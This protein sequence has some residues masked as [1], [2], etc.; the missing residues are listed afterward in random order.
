MRARAKGLTALAALC[1]GLAVAAVAC[2][3]PVDSASNR[4][5]YSGGGSSSPS[6]NNAP[7]GNVPVQVLLTDDP[8]PY[9][10]LIAVSL[11]ASK[12]EIGSNGQYLTLIEWQGSP[13]VYEVLSLAN[14]KTKSIATKSIPPGHYDRIRFTTPAVKVRVTNGPAFDASAPN[15]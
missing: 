14:G 3:P 4:T 11:R 15:G 9:A 5:T 8:F 6:N 13:G 7:V 10:Y 2:A 1:T 12:L